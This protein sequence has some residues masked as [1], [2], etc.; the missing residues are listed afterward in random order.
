MAHIGIKLLKETLLLYTHKVLGIVSMTM[1]QE[2]PELYCKNT[3]E[4]D[5]KICQKHTD[6]PGDG[7]QWLA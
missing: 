5:R 7:F 6:T 2:C 3:A 1:E 4:L